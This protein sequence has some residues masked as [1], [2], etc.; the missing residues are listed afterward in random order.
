M[1]TQHVARTACREDLAKHVVTNAGGSVAVMNHESLSPNEDLVQDLLAVL[2]LAAV[3]PDDVR[4]SRW[5]TRRTH[6]NSYTLASASVFARGKLFTAQIRT[7]RVLHGTEINADL[8]IERRGLKESIPRYLPLPRSAQ[9]DPG[10]RGGHF[11]P[12]HELQS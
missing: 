8:N 9:A 6:R 7:A 5:S 10:G 2:A 3:P 11:P 1:T 4:R 12:R